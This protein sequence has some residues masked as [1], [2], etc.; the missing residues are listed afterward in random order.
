MRFGRVL[1][2]VVLGGAGGSVAVATDSLGI[3]RM[4]RQPATSLSITY[5]VRIFR[6]HYRLGCDPP[7]GTLPRAGGACAAIA[8]TPTMV[9]QQP[10]VENLPIRKCPAHEWS[11]AVSGSYRGRPVDATFSSPC[12]EVEIGRRW[13]SHLPS[14]DELTRVR[15]DR[16]LGPVD[17][18]ESAAA[19]RDRLGPPAERK[20]HMQVYHLGIEGTAHQE[21]PVIFAVGY[22]RSNRVTSLIWNGFASIFGERLSLTPHRGS[23]VAHWH[24]AVCGGRA[25]RSDHRLADGR[26]TTIIWSSDH[27]TVIVT[28]TPASACSGAAAT[29][30][31]GCRLGATCPTEHLSVPVRFGSLAARSRR[32][33]HSRNQ[34]SA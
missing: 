2:L 17:L 14:R 13:L 34:P 12:G 6:L 32:G 21:L 22:G 25:A 26:P 29:A 19:V 24:A 11:I 4:S 15:V 5:D 7:S 31:R 27:A 3:A 23:P 28:S 20:A 8:R 18:G 30:P 16:G 9:F 1:F 10:L 33:A